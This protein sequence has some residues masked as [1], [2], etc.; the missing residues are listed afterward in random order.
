VAAAY[1]TGL[2]DARRQILEWA[3]DQIQ[4]LPEHRT[5]VAHSKAEVLRDL[6]DRLS[7]NRSTP[8]AGQDG[9]R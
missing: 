2:A 8:G 5:P 6:R 7:G 9:A 1:R 4:A 3:D